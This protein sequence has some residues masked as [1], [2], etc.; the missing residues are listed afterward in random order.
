MKTTLLLSLLL[1]FCTVVFSA[2]NQEQWIFKTN[3]NIYS[4]PVFFGETIFFGS[5]DSIFYAVNKNDGSKIW[6]FKTGGAIHSNPLINENSVYFGSADGNLYS[7][8]IMTGKLNWKFESKGEKILDVWDYYLSS[9]K[10]ANGIIYWGS[11]DGNFYAINAVCGTL[12]WSFQTGAIIHATPLISNDMVYFGDYNG[13]FY[14]L[15]AENGVIN[16]Q[17]KTIGDTYFPK[18]EIQKGATIDNGIV[19]FG[20]RDFNI[21]ALDAKSGTGHWNR[22]ERGSW[23][24]AEPLIYQGNVFFGTS[25]TH[26]FY[27]LDKSNGNPVWEIPLPMRVYGQAIANNNTIYFGCFDGKMRGVDSETGKIVWEFQT[28]G[29]KMNYAKVYNKEGQFK[30]GFEL[31]GT[32]YLGTEKLILSLG[33]I[34]STPAVENNI[35][36]FGSSD[37]N[38]YAV[39]LKQ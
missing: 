12:E 13:K 31:Y 16:W 10:V 23:I 33:F 8:N 26:R 39:P 3:G 1:L 20:S 28:E 36:Y 15:N 22:K 30:E 6:D 5:G 11:G 38:F 7:L 32:D 34:L 19:Y 29:S 21:Y 4:S 27:C 14:A 35:I 18:G 24:I 2:S 37:G 17:F 9:P 25:D